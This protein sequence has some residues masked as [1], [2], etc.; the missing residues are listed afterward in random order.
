MVQHTLSFSFLYG[1]DL[2]SDDL[3]DDDIQRNFIHYN[4]KPYTVTFESNNNKELKKEIKKFVDDVFSKL[5]NLHQYN[6]KE[7]ESLKDTY[8]FCLCPEDLNRYHDSI[9]NDLYNQHYW[10]WNR[11]Q[12][13]YIWAFALDYTRFEIYDKEF[14]K[15][16]IKWRRD[17]QNDPITGLLPAENYN[18]NPVVSLIQQFANLGFDA[19]M[20]SI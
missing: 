7:M 19:R 14:D 8:L 9:I 13:Y 17:D 5:R 12:K 4:E 11:Y 18:I 10:V 20:Y 1:H 15:E 2:D 16:L 3:H 6:L